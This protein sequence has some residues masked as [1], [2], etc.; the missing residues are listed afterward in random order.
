MAQS[1]LKNTLTTMTPGRL[2]D[3]CFAYVFSDESDPT[4]SP[5]K[6]VNGISNMCIV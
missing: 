1:N 2:L 3:I 6:P 5:L 4:P